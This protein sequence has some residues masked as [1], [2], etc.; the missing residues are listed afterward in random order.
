MIQYSTATPRDAARRPLRTQ[1]DSNHSDARQRGNAVPIG[2][3]WRSFGRTGEN[4]PKIPNQDGTATRW[5]NGRMITVVV[6]TS[7]IDERT[8]VDRAGRPHS[9][10]LRVE[11]RFP[12]GP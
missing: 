11:E 1:N 9:S 10:D 3:V 8:W 4:S 5:V 12:A 6:Q 7:G 2:K